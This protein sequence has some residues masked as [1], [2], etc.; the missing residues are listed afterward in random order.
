MEAIRLKDFKTKSLRSFYNSTLLRADIKTE[1]KDLMMGHA[2]LGARGHYDYDEQ[3]IK[4]NY[5]KAFKFLSINGLQTRTDIAKIKAEMDKNKIQFAD[6]LQEQKLKFEKQITD[7]HNFV[8]KNLDP[9]LDLM[10]DEVIAKVIQQRLIE[11]REEEQ[12]KAQAEENT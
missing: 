7:V 8:H 4:D 11:K 10:N 1:V 5:T 2:K 3:T 9:V 12:A 6:L